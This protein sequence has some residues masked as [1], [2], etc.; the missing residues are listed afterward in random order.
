[1]S[2]RKS[3]WTQ[4]YINNN[5]KSESGDSNNDKTFAKILDINIPATKEDQGI[6]AFDSKVNWNE[7]DNSDI[8]DTISAKYKQ[9]AKRFFNDYIGIHSR[10]CLT[11]YLHNYLLKRLKL[12]N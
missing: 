9:I 5:R 8:D 12:T 6:N 2:R 4:R 1:M 7:T 10:S 11:N 3:E